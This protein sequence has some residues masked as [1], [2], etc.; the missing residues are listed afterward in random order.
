MHGGVDWRTT[1]PMLGFEEAPEAERWRVP[2]GLSLGR[3]NLPWA[4]IIISET[5]ADVFD[6]DCACARAV[7]ARIRRGVGTSVTAKTPNACGWYGAGRPLGD[8]PIG[9]RTR[10]S[11]PGMPRLRR[12]A[13][14]VLSLRRNPRTN[15]KL[16]R[17]VVTQQEFFPRLPSAI[18][19]DVT[20]HL[21]SWAGTRPSFVALPA[22]KHL[23]AWS[24]VSANG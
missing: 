3:R 12:R 1:A 6:P 23:T 15:P 21:P 19:P 7:G 22:V 13:V 14:S 2:L 11:K 17:R 10:R 8:R 20:N 16:H 24:I 9:A 18:G 4:A 5:A